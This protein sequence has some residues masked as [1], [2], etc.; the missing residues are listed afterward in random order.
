MQTPAA[1]KLN[2]LFFGA[3]SMAIPLA[4]LME[5][6]GHRVTMYVRPKT[7]P[8]RP[9]EIPFQVVAT[10]SVL[11]KAVT[12]PYRPA[13]VDKLAKT[14]DFDY[15]LAPLPH[16][17]LSAALP[18]LSKIHPDVPI[19]L[20]GNH[21]DDFALTDKVLGERYFYGFPH[22]GGALDAG[23]WYGSLRSAFSLGEADGRTSP[24]LEILAKA[25]AEAGF[26]T[27]VRKD[28]RDWFLA[29]FAFNAG[30][31]AAAIQARGLLEM[32]R[33]GEHARLA[34]RC[35]REGFEIVRARGVDPDRFQSETGITKLPEF[36]SACLVRLL[37]HTAMLKI[38]AAHTHAGSEEMCD[39][40]QRV[41][42]TGKEYGIATP[43]LSSTL[44][45]LLE[46]KQIK[47]P[48]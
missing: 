28:I 6:T 36:L 10:G 32:M 43:N 35:M 24:R 19:V 21:W 4:A 38:T 17:A 40:A 25:L 15:V 29:H 42:A 48:T 30:M 8:R 20:I 37:S 33:S 3:G 22:F 44:G 26:K 27:T 31:M 41:I 16:T 2:I 11:K 34:I 7:I 45:A 46:F 1:R 5:S 9:K 13:Y 18:M 14:K 47:K 39:Y 12:R 23:V